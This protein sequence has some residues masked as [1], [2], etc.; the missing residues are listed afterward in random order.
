MDKDKNNNN[1]PFSDE[2]YDALSTGDAYGVPFGAG[3][4]IKDVEGVGYE[5]DSSL[6]VL[7]GDAYK[8]DEKV[9]IVKK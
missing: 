9:K 8:P 2:V 6:S 1:Q 4:S 5:V 3:F 7:P